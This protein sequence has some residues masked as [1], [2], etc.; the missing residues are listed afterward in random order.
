MGW[1]TN[2]VAPPSNDWWDDDRPK[3]MRPRTREDIIEAIKKQNSSRW[4]R[5][6]HDFKWLKRRMK[7]MGL[8]PDDAREL[9]K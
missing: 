5:L 9:L 6:N 4:W 8:S 2:S 3:M 1:W 7:K